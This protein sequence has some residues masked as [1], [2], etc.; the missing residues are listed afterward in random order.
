V[1]LTSDDVQDILNLLDGLPYGEMHLQT[2]RFSLWLRRTPDGEWTQ[3]VQVRSEPNMTSG[4]AE[5]DVAA[6]T[7]EAAEVDGAAVASEATGV[8]EAAGTDG[9]A[10]PDGMRAVRSPLPG[11]FY[12]APMPGAP[13]FVDTG[14]HVE[15]DTVVAIIE[16]MK[17]MNSVCAGVSGTVARILLADAQAAGKDTALMWIREDA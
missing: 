5:T 1:D 6:A 4:A 11:T 8:G 16:T 15:P 3:E 14:S 12:R 2:A 13:P 10:A 17:L 9:G 7:G